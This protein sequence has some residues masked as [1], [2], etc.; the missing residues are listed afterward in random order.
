MTSERIWPKYKEAGVHELLNKA[1]D[2]LDKRPFV[3]GTIR[4]RETGGVDT[5]GAL[6]L[7]A[8][9]RYDSLSDNY[10][11]MGIPRNKVAVFYAT[12]DF[13]ESAIDDGD[14]LNWNDDPR[15]TGDNVIDFLTNLAVE[16]EL[17]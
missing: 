10:C 9:V 13:I 12:I 7:A 3:Q 16:L 4:H 6:A 15:R 11:E 14:I 5:M 17:A 8:G 1:A 2:I